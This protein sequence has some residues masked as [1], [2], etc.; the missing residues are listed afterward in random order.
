VVIAQTWYRPWRAFVDGT[1]TRI[2]RANYA[3]QALQVPAGRHTVR[4]IYKD[5]LFAIGAVIS[6]AT[7]AAAA[8]GVFWTRRLSNLA[9]CDS[10]LPPTG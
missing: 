3:F 2:L 7:L 6:L 4:L 5:S 10:G 9:S 1:G 8:F